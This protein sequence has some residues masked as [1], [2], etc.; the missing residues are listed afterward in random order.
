MQVN[1]IGTDFRAK[2]SGDTILNTTT[3]AAKST[4]YSAIA[5][6]GGNPKHLF[7]Q[8]SELSIFGQGSG[9]VGTVGNDL[10]FNI[11]DFD[12]VVENIPLYNQ[13]ILYVKDYDK[14]GKLQ[15]VKKDGVK[16]RRIPQNLPDNHPFKAY[17]SV[18]FS[19]GAITT[20]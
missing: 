8:I 5:F 1:A 3:K 14:D 15:G 9:G 10:F 20:T 2:S 17:D 18:G 6:K 12:R 19:I 7:H 11:K 16:L 4:G 13:E